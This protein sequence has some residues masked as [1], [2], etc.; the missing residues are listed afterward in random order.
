[1]FFSVFQNW[2]FFAVLGPFSGNFGSFS[3]IFCLWPSYRSH[4]MTHEP[5]FVEYDLC[6]YIK[7][8]LYSFFEN[9]IFDSITSFFMCIFGRF[10]GIFCLWTSYRSHVLTQEII[11]LKI[12]SLGLYQEIFKRKCFW[13]YLGVAYENLGRRL[14]RP[15]RSSAA[16]RCA[17][18][19]MFLLPTVRVGRLTARC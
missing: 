14:V 11:I 6:D 12:W 18:C 5:I 16:R 19:F 13:P 10:S 9:L 7:K 1:M 17:C 3:G 15:Q 4:P 8:N 2:I